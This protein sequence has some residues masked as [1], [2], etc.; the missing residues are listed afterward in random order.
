MP[1]RFVYF[2]SDV[3]A[4]QMY[5]ETREQMMEN[6]REWLRLIEEHPDMDIMINVTTAG[7]TISDMT[8]YI[9]R[10]RQEGRLF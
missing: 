10:K 6:L 3:P 2:H 4:D 7:F 1:E 5:G 8:S 9:E